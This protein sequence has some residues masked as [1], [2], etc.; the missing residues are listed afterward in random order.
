[1]AGSVARGEATEHSDLDLVIVYERLPHAYRE[2]F[3]D[4]GWPVET[5]VH[6]PETLDYFFMQVDGPAGVPSLAR[7]VLDGIELAPSALGQSLKA[8]ARA[9]LDAGPPPWSARELAQRRYMITDLV[10]DLRAPRSAA[11]RVATGARLYEL[12][13]DCL[14]RARG[15]WSARGKN[16]PRALATVDAQL[17]ADFVSAFERLFTA[18]ETAPLVHFCNAA[19]HPY[20]GLLFAG[21]RLDAPATWRRPG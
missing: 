2:S 4:A 5:F 11:E 9:V 7:M 18:G 21:F 14:L 3:V 13:G 19:L 20:G 6:D 12:L 1:L 15:C 8:R 10:D 16:L 17:G